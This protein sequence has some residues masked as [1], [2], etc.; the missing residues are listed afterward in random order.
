MSIG[1]VD[2][3]IAILIIIG[4]IIGFKNGVIKE[5]TKFETIFNELS[6]YILSI[7]II[8]NYFSSTTIYFKSISSHYRISRIASK[9]DCL[10]KS[11]N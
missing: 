11:T 4:G 1:F 2:F 5:G 8:L 7:N 6:K 9:N 3:I 10:S